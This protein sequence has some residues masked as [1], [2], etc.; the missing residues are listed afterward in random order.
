[1][2]KRPLKCQLALWRERP[3]TH[4]QAEKLT[5]VLEALSSDVGRWNDSSQLVPL[6]AYLP[7]SDP[8]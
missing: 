3:K 7:A 4:P 8:P 1:M 6:F 2:L 5:L